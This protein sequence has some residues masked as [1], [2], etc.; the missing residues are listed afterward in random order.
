LI[1]L[2][3]LLECN[4]KSTGI[5]NRIMRAIPLSVLTNNLVQV[6]KLYKKLYP[7]GEYDDDAFN[8]MNK[9][10]DPSRKE[11]F[12]FIIENG[13]NIYILI[14]LFLDNKRQDNTEDD[15][16]NEFIRQFPED[17][18]SKLLKNNPLGELTKLGKSILGNSIGFMK[19]VKRAVIDEGIMALGGGSGDEKEMEAIQ[20]KEV[21]KNQLVKEAVA[22]FRA[23]MGHLEIIREGKIQK[24]YFPIL[25]FCKFLSKTLKVEF[26]EAVVRTSTKT[27]LA[28]LMEQADYLIKNMKHDEKLSRIFNKYKIFGLLANHVTLWEY[29]SFYIGIALNIIIISSY[30]EDYGSTPHLFLDPSKD[31]MSIITTLGILNLVFSSLVVANFF[32]K[33][34]PLLL[35]DIWKGFFSRKFNIIKTPLRFVFKLI[36]S[37]LRGL[38]DFDIL[39]YCLVMFF[40]LMGLLV[41]PA[42]FFFQLTD[43]LR[44]EL[45]KNVVKAVWNPRISL[46][47]TLLVFILLEYYFAIIGFSVFGLHY[48]G[49]AA[50]QSL[51]DCFLQTFD[52]TFK[53]IIY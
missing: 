36:H 7:N 53:V 21:G 6:Y 22:F 31:T 26:H 35:G 19:C 37:L 27:K 52:H 33:R 12:E 20:N 32:L 16:L 4:D 8:H 46:G 2:V 3:S 42:F 29:A 11:Y 47:L 38:K 45:L 28:Y 25:P 10:Y 9:E 48:D 17:N 24:I 15:E 34:A 44:N 40:A 51:W 41:H 49:G 39:Y 43:F 50:C 13:F 30:S 14:N 1:T 23:N 5:A 18:A